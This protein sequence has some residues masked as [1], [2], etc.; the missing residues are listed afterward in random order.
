MKIN[1]SLLS[2]IIKEEIKFALYEDKD[3]DWAIPV[4][5]Y[6]IKITDY[7]KEANFSADD[8][9]KCRN[10]IKKMSGLDAEKVLHYFINKVDP[11]RI[12]L[13]ADKLKIKIDSKDL[14]L[15]PPV[16]EKPSKINF[17]DRRS[18]REEPQDPR[19]DSRTGKD[20]KNWV[21]QE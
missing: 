16:Y 7:N 21:H 19:E 4:L 3:P 10:T 6:L 20:K 17:T 11:Q 9:E 15:T 13:A 5:N 8:S 12:T 2:K 1:K 14:G 18:T